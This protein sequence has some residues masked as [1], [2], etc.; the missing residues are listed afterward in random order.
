MKGSVNV[1]P[2]SVKSGVEIV[3][4]IKFCHCCWWQSK[5]N[6]SFPNEP[7]GEWD[8]LIIQNKQII[9]VDIKG[10]CWRWNNQKNPIIESHD[11]YVTA[12]HNTNLREGES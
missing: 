1:T 5:G 12:I 3:T 2:T 7:Q 10:N 8:I 6:I 11:D 4:R 9:L